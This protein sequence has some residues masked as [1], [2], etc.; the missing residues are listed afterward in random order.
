MRSQI[1]YRNIFK[2]AYRIVKKYRIFFIDTE[3]KLMKWNTPTTY[4]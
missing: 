3:I 2:I 4:G 1:N